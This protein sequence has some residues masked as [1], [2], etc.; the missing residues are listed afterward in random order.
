[1][2][3]GGP[4]S[5]LPPPL[6]PA[7]A[8]QPDPARWIAFEAPARVRLH[9]GK[10]ELGQGILTALAQILADAL[11][12][13]V[14][15]V[16]VH[17][18]STCAGPDEGHTVGSLSVEQS[19]AALR[20]L[21]ACLHGRLVALAG[22]GLK[23]DPASL[24]VEDGVV[25]WRGEATAFSYWSAA[26][27]LLAKPVSAEAAAADWR[28]G[29]R[30]EV[31]RSLPRIDL[32]S[33]LRGGGSFIHDMELPVMRHAAVLRAPHPLARL[34]LID[35][36]RVAR[37]H[38]QVAILRRGDFVACVAEA[39]RDARRALDLLQSTANWT[40]PAGEDTA[41]A[42]PRDGQCISEWLSTQ[43]AEN[44]V[45]EA[46]QRPEP[47]AQGLRYA[48][49]WT[50]PFIAHASIG[51]ACA[52]AHDH[53]GILEVWSHSQGIF[54]L[55]QQI[56]RVLGREPGT[57]QVHHRAGA[58]C[59][60]HN[61]ADDVALDAALVAT[62]QP[63]V[64]IRAQWSRAEELSCAPVG[65][66]MAVHLDACLDAQGRIAEWNAR[67]MSTSHGTRPGMHGEPHL[68]AAASW[69]ARWAS[70]RTADV[71]EAA[72]G[73]ASRNARP[74]YE[75]GALNLALD[76]VASRVRSSS[77]RS[78]GAHANVFAIEGM[79]EELAALADCEAAEFRLR[80]LQDPR[81]RRVLDRVLAL[82]DWHAPDRH[83]QETTLGLGCCG[84]LTGSSPSG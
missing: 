6:P 72:G 73:G 4:L 36:E 63:G 22:C 35:E 28:A 61:G 41:G 15:Q 52:L 46:A 78:L 62:L 38:P 7:L 14:Q 71:P 26:P 20:A 47:P 57:V 10:V 32:P 8:S 33:K 16:L 58:G 2:N 70:P 64:P 5:E 49:V 3:P 23:T 60:G 54:A 74:L 59:Y 1:M 27:D 21:G 56:A 51:L 79:M 77:L 25:R 18:A 81:A 67:V 55:R 68:L 24:R 80:H 29:V 39:E 13:R 76:F 82:S 66:A 30:Q 45:L 50:R 31:G 40:Q 12:V 11:G 75:V 34:V 37:R 44:V 19:G 84:S 53:D 17:C 42:A 43:A 9:T 83:P 48:A 65:A 69:D